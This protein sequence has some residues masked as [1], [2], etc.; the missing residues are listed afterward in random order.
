MDARPLLL[1][2]AASL[3]LARAT[4]GRIPGAGDLQRIGGETLR[5][6][7]PPSTLYL[8]FVAAPQPTPA[9]PPGKFGIDPL[10]PIDIVYGGLSPIATDP[11][12]VAATGAD[13]VRLNFVLGPWTGM[14]DGT[15]HHGRTWQ[16]TY[17]ALVRGYRRAGLHIYALV[18][19][20]AMRQDPGDSL[21]AAPPASLDGSPGAAWI[22]GY[23]NHLVHILRLFAADLTVVETLNEPD[24]WHGGATHW[25]HPG[26][27]AILQQRAYQAVK[28]DPALA[29]LTVVSGPLQGF[30]NNHNAAAGYLQRVYWEGQTRFG[31][32]QEGMPYPFDGIGYHLYLNDRYYV[33]AQAQAAA[34]TARYALYLDQIEAV[35]R[36][37]EGAP[38]PLYLSEIGFTSRPEDEQRQAENLRTVLAL[39]AQ[40]P[41]V[42]LAIWFALQ[43]FPLAGQVYTYGLYRPGDLTPINRKPAFAAYQALTAGGTP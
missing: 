3:A 40:D 42:S 43:D 21:R 24:D 5:R 12:A 19:Y 1:A 38:R 41:R 29:H 4:A 36:A 20:E 27:F 6:L 35:V 30:A 17:R 7:Q 32:G 34:V 23:V 18:S 22:D 14:D 15:R 9:E 25:V 33:D 2:L 37:A 16:E 28:G 8:P 31:W 13:W 10:H 11:A 26:W 39:V